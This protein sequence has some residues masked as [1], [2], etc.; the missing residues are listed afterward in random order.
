MRSR[1]DRRMLVRAQAAMAVL[2]LSG[3]LP[4]RAQLLEARGAPGPMVTAGLLVAS[5]KRAADSQ[6]RTG[7]GGE[8]AFV[9]PLRLDRDLP[10]LFAGGWA[11][12]QGVEGFSGARYG[13]GARLQLSFFGLDAGLAQQ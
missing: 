10:P 3:A 6:W 11:Q 5:G 12:L 7:I 4:A 9:A 13:A 1:A 8:L 2:L